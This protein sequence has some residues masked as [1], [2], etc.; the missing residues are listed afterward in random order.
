MTDTYEL[1]E[2]QSTRHQ[3]I[4]KATE[5]TLNIMV[6]VSFFAIFVASFFFTIASHVE[7]S[8]V[9]RNTERI[10]KELT[11]TALDVLPEH[12]LK[13]LQELMDKHLTLPDMRE[14]D[15]ETS[16]KNTKLIRDTWTVLLSVFA[17][18]MVIVVVVWAIFKHIAGPQGRAGRD[19]P[20][21]AHLFKENGILLIFVAVTELIFLVCFVAFYRSIDANK[22]RRATVETIKLFAQAPPPS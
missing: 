5:F 4:L 7:V 6:A 12:E 9:K 13:E 14:I 22:I 19:Y 1:F 3:K 20:D 11:S 2:P 15:R 10:V 8:A 16:E 21:I 17:G 18:V